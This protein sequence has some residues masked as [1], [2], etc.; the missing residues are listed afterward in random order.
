MLLK[1]CFK[2]GDTKSLAEFYEAKTSAD[3]YSGKCRPCTGADSRNARYQRVYGISVADYDAMLLA[4]DGRCAICLSDSPGG[5]AQHFSVDH[6]HR[7]GRV[8]GLLC[9]SCNGMLGNARDRREVLLAAVDY[10]DESRSR[11]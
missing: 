6:C 4:Q 1:Q 9:L 7:T 8:R 11:P 3:G 10:L 5:V 2:C